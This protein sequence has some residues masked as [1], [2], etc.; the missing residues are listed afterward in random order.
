[1]STPERGEEPRTR[2]APPKTSPLEWLVAGLSL[3]LVLGVA[4]FLLQD[5]VRSPPSPPHIT[6]EVDSVVR[7]GTGYLVEFRALN[8]GRTTAAGL[9]VEGEILADT[10]S[11]ETTQVTIDY[12][13]AKGKT[14]AGLF[15]TNDPRRHRLELRPKGYDRP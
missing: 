5:A 13:P 15:F 2:A 7:A 12:V 1:M 4:G 3:L 6:L 10:G 11:V 14:A 9:E 8:A